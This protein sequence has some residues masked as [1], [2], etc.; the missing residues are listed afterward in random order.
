VFRQIFKPDTSGIQDKNYVVKPSYSVSLTAKTND[1]HSPLV[2]RSFPLITWILVS[3]A[4]LREVATC[5]CRGTRYP[6]CNH[7]LPGAFKGIGQS[8]LSL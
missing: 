3:D 8:P 7:I 4:V 5:L 2:Y 6:A 1:R